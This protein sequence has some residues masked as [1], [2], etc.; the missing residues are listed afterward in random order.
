MLNLHT[1][2]PGAKTVL[3]LAQADTDLDGAIIDVVSTLTTSNYTIGGFTNAYVVSNSWGYSET[4]GPSPGTETSLEKAA[5]FGISFDFSSMDC[6]DGTYSSSWTC[7]AEGAHPTVQYPASSSYTTAVGGSSLF[8]DNNWNYSFEALWG[9][10]YDGAFYAGS[11]GGISQLYGPVAWQGSI[12][13]FTAGGYTAG[14]VG[15]YNKR[16]VPDVAML[17]DPY[18]GLTIYENGN[19]FVYGG[20]SLSCPLFSGTVTLLNQART[21]LNGGTPNPIG[22]VAPYLYMNNSALRNGQALNLIAPPH[23]II[24]GAVL[25]PNGAPLSAFSIYDSSYNYVLTFGWDSSLTIAPENQF[26]N[27]GVG[28]GSP[29]LPNFLTLMAQF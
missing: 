5:A 6:G 19:I 11:T 15:S 27:D 25:P 28:V 4:E 9:S 21:L 3:V 20:T 24:D 1:I 22:Q 29:N 17:A 7:T 10:Y 16:A 13:S 8:V 12:N 14:T 2:A 23:S 26:W 18:T